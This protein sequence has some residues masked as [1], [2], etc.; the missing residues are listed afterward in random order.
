MSVYWNS[1]T[2]I[3]NLVKLVIIGDGG[4]GKT[5]LFIAYCCDEFP[6]NY[7]PVV[8]DNY[9][10]A[11]PFAEETYHLQFWDTGGGEEY[12]TLRPLSY[13]NTS[14]F[15]VCFSV[16]QPASFRNVTEMWVPEIKHHCPNTPFLLLGTKVDLR[17]DRATLDKLD[18]NK[19]KP[20]SKEEGE[21]LAKSLKAAAYIECSSLTREGVKNVFDQAILHH[22]QK[23]EQRKMS[24]KKKCNVL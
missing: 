13:P 15:L 20:V 23:V 19:G 7:V 1:G 12:D 4:V 14:I 21:L 11:V 2:L 3:R 24:E 8:F 18:K 22:L 9:V 5:S 10:K 6:Y 17:V 16:T